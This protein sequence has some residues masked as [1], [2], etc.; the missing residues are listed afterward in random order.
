VLRKKIG[1]DGRP[2]AEETIMMVSVNDRAE[3]K[4]TKQ[5]E[6]LN[7]E[8]A[9]VEAQLVA[10]GDRFRDGKKLRVK[11]IL[12]HRKSGCGEKLNHTSLCYRLFYTVSAPK[13][14][15]L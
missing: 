2:R 1:L 13:H 6:G 14:R 9:T 11:C 4:L 3:R 12:P 10:W 15:R 7:V 5:F 8:W